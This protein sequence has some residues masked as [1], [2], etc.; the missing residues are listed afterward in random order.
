[1][2]RTGNKVSMT[3]QGAAG[4][5]L[6]GRRVDDHER[7][8]VADGSC[9][10]RRMIQERIKWG[11]GFVLD[12]QKQ[13]VLSERH[14]FE[15]RSGIIFSKSGSKKSISGL[16]SV[17]MCL[18]SSPER[19]KLMGTMMAPRAATAPVTGKNS[20]RFLVR[21]AIRSPRRIPWKPTSR[22]PHTPGHVTPRK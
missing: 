8:A 14:N 13:S 7:I 22:S 21:T 9:R 3:E 12:D 18:I 11:K 2:N 20:G 10:S 4:F 15:K 17:R 1:M 6:N 16:V 5:P 19:R